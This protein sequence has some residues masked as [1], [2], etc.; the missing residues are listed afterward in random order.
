MKEFKVV[1]RWIKMILYTPRAVMELNQCDQIAWYFFNIW[2][3]TTTNI[4][5]IAKAGNFPR[6]IQ[7][8]SKRVKNPQEIAKYFN[9]FAKS[10]HTG[11]Q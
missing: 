1:V 2:P 8:F 7:K 4:W 3:I 5:P 10:G 9:F 6:M 11:A